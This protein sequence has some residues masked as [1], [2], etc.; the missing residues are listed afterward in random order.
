MPAATSGSGW[1]A[2]RGSPVWTSGPSSH[3]IVEAGLREPDR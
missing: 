1:A 3:V 2:S